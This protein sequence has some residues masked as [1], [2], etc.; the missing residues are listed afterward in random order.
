MHILSQEEK[1]RVNEIALSILDDVGVRIDHPEIFEVLCQM[2]GKGDRAASVVRMSE[3]MVTRAIA[4][5]PKKVAF[6]DLEGR[7]TE[8][9]NGAQPLFWGGNALYFARGRKREVM[10]ETRFVEMARLYD[11]LENVH[12]IVGT[13]IGDFPPKT[14]DFVGLR[15]LAE[16][17]GKHMRPVIFTPTGAEVIIEMCQAILEMERYRGASLAQLPIVS[18]GFTIVSPLHWTSLAL[19]VFQ[20]TS[21]FGIPVMVNSEVVAGTTAPVTLPGALCLAVAEVMSGIVVVQALEKGRPVVFNAGFSHVFDMQTAETLTGCSENGLLQGAGDQMAAH[22][23]LPSAS[24]MSTESMVPDGQA[25]AE[26]VLTGLQH[27]HSGANL[28]WGIGNLESTLTICLEQAVIDNEIAAS[29]LRSMKGLGFTEDRLASGLIKEMG[30]RSDYLSADHTFRYYR[31]EILFSD[32]WYRE[33]RENWE[34]KGEPD[35]AERASRIVQE[36]LSRR[37]RS[38]L[39]E[40]TRKRLEAMEKKWVQKLGS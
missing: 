40:T 28:I 20:K 8:V 1:Q 13:S 23:G 2:G 19:E 30:H 17:G 29:I 7:I 22:Y 24:W 14:R 36:R 11:T 18:F 10:T 27:A 37:C 25:S 3:E 33:R 21:G 38:L 15:R 35:L 39:D 16:N 4:W 32:L 12:A 6:A 31:D 5:C 9:Y 34:Q 26:K